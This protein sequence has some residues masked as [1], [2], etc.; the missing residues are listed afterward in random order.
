MG[1]ALVG[2]VETVGKGSSG[3]LVDDA[4][5]LETSDGTG[6]LGRGTLGVVEVSRHGDDS[7]VDLRNS[8]KKPSA[9]AV[10]G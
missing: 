4:H 5:H 10:L 3:R 8:D 7:T 6:V 2:L 9:P 1:F